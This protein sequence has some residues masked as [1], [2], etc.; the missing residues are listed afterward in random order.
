MAAQA[1]LMGYLGESVSE[2]LN[3]LGS[4]LMQ[5]ES[6][7]QVQL[8]VVNEL[9]ARNLLGILA[10]RHSEGRVSLYRLQD[11]NTLRSVVTNGRGRR[12]RD[13]EPDS[14]RWQAVMEF[15]RSGQPVICNNVDD[16]NQ[17]P[18]HWEGTASGY[19][20][21]VSC[22]VVVDDEVFGMLTFDVP[23]AEALDGNDANALIVFAGF[24]A[25]AANLVQDS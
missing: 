24:A 17:R 13:F 8:D 23:E 4:M 12:P 2:V 19:K 9:I 5:P 11:D 1:S 20:A 22:P 18:S 15:L 10:S 6:D 16:P 3:R 21:F 14:P 25:F 7:R